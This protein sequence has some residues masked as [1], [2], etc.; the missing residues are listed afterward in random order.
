M[1][2][3]LHRMANFQPEGPTAGLRTPS[4]VQDDPYGFKMLLFQPEKVLYWSETAFCRPEIFFN[5]MAF[6][7]PTRALCLSEGRSVDLRALCQSWKIVCHLESS[8]FGLLKPYFSLGQ[9]SACL[10]VIR[11]FVGLMCPSADLKALF[12]P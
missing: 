8:R 7:R 3:Y 5:E 11:S 12:W 9:P 6:C 1:V 10:I 2:L 4:G